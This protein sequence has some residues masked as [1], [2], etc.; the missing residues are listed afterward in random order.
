[1]RDS[2]R[3]TFFF[4]WSLERQRYTLACAANKRLHAKCPITLTLRI[5]RRSNVSFFSHR[6]ARTHAQFQAESRGG[7]GEERYEV[8]E[9]QAK[10]KD[11][12]TKLYDS[13]VNVHPIVRKPLCFS[14]CSLPR[15]PRASLAST[16]L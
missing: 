11:Q 5:V 3:L 10:V 4:I 7:F 15:Q 8:S 14:S 13:L 2:L 16:L 9:F 1:M 6:V 12:F